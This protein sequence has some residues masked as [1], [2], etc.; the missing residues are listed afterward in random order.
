MFYFNTFIK[1]FISILLLFSTNPTYC[2]T[3]Y[4]KQNVSINIVNRNAEEISSLEKNRIKEYLLENIPIFNNLN[5]LNID[6][7]FSK[8][9]KNISKSNGNN[10]DCIVTLNYQNKKRPVLLT[11][12]DKDIEFT[13]LHEIGHCILNKDT[14]F[15]KI[16][17]QNISILQ[18]QQLERL[19][20]KKE[21][22]Y[23]KEI[24]KVPPLLVYHEIF[25]DTYSVLAMKM[26][27]Y[28]NYIKDMHNL[29]SIRFKN[30]QIKSEAHLSDQAIILAMS[31][32]NITDN[33]LYQK[34]EE[35][36]QKLFIEYLINNK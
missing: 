11:T 3:I 26:K 21:E 7:I 27:P 30:K 25:A 6:I 16:A 35:I 29:I 33:N 28:Q 15:K 5:R 23:L 13:T 1:I 19:I 31:Q 9:V 10:Y 34:T 12:I 4:K 8:N 32:N 36:S 14:M 17:W 20:S 2:Q 24:E 18:Q 22:N